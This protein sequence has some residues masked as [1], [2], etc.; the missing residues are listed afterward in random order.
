MTC[1]QKYWEM[2]YLDIWEE[3]PDNLYN[4]WVVDVTEYILINSE[5]VERVFTAP[6]WK[7]N[8]EI[9]DMCSFMAD[10]LSACIKR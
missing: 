5:G 1:T 3:I 8:T 4:H 2:Q 7:F 9:W 10:Y 6:S